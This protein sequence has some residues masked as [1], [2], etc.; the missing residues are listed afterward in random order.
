MMKNLPICLL[1]LM[2]VCANAQPK[3]VGTLANSGPEAGGSI[4]RNNLPA[5]TPGVIKTFNNL[6]PHHAL[7]GVAAGDADWLYGM[8][9]YNGTNQGGAFYKIKRDGTGFSKIYDIPPYFYLTAIPFY[10]TDGLVYFSTGTDV[11]KYDPGTSAIT[12]IPLS[13]GAAIQRT[14]TID[15][16]DWMYFLSSAQTAV[17]T[18]VKTDG[19][20]SIDLHTF[21]G[22]TDG[23]SG[24]AG[25]TSIP[26]DSVVG[27]TSQGGVNDFGTIY[28]IKKD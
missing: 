19:S 7:G 28:S 11:I 20:Q 1:L 6:A 2:A 14:M 9:S 16:N 4:F 18:K 8:L 21:N 5:T 13:I 10:H 27:L 12:T 26:G 3:L 15:E 17:L 24:I 22:T 23:W 25:I